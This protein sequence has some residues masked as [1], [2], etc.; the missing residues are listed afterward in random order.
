MNNDES[1]MTKLKRPKKKISIDEITEDLYN[2]DKRKLLEIVTDVQTRLYNIKQDSYHIGK[3]LYEAKQILPHGMFIPWI[4]HYFK[5]DLPYSTANFY[6]NIFETFEGD[7]RLVKLIPTKYLMMVTQKEFPKETLKL[8]KEHSENVS[9][10]SIKQVNEVYE[11]FKNG[12]IRQSQ[13]IVLARDQ[14]KHGID[15]WKNDGTHRINSN[16][17]QSLYWGG[18]NI[19]KRIQQLIETARNMKGLYPYD[20]NSDEHKKLMRHIDEIIKELHEM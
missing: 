5:E 14:I 12:E 13:F 19:L 17:R 4:K 15:V 8:I 3:L 1:E 16:M 18:G 11:L 6:M 20:P 7:P 9:K 2:T 10:D